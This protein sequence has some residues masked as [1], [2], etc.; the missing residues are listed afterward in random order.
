MSIVS[1]GGKGTQEWVILTQAERIQEIPSQPWPPMAVEEEVTRENDSRD[2]ENDLRYPDLGVLVQHLDSNLGNKRK[3]REGDEVGDWF[4]NS[5]QRAP[6]S[7]TV[8]FWINT[9][10]ED[11]IAQGRSAF[12]N[13]PTTPVLSEVC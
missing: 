1:W 13:S 10:V 4:R 9:V 11:K 6:V 3:N 12:L 5:R 8:G 2:V 7:V